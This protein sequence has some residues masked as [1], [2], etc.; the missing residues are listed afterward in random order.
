ML[1]RIT[2]PNPA[3]TWA[4]FLYTALP[5]ASSVLPNSTLVKLTICKGL[6][7]FRMNI[8]E[9][10]PFVILGIVTNHKTKGGDDMTEHQEIRARSLEI[11]LQAASAEPRGSLLVPDLLDRARNLAPQI[12]AYIRNEG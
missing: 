8:L 7:P 3:A 9:K 6:L 10:T 1:G 5:I 2:G 4:Y 12:E 11:A